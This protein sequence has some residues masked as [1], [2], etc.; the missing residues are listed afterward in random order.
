[1]MIKKTS[2]ASVCQN[3]VANSGYLQGVA[4]CLRNE[5]N[6]LHTASAGFHPTSALM[7]QIR[8]R[9]E[10]MCVERLASSGGGC[11]SRCLI[12]SFRTGAGC[13]VKR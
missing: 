2:E 5:Y 6:P 8:M 11:L 1:M 13:E 7:F 10:L 9:I 4:I 3:E 12:R